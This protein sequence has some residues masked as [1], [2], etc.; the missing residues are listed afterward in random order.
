LIE[1]KKVDV[2]IK[3]FGQ[4]ARSY[5]DVHLV[6]V[7][8]GNERQ[9]LEELAK[10]LNIPRII[11][12][13][14][15]TTD[16][17]EYFAMCNVFVLPGLG[18]LAI[19]DAM[20]CRKP[21]ICGCA[22]GSEKDLIEDGVTGYIIPDAMFGEDI[23]AAKILSIIGDEKVNAEMGERAH[24]RYME[25]A[26]FEGMVNNFERAIAAIVDCQRGSP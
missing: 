22:D 21:V 20:V 13:G 25:R 3:A 14:S 18:G 23:L 9:S 1:R 24:L 16:V 8:G 19:N 11:F 4:I 10:S 12:V 26:T 2:L 15:K 17:Y 6:I 7:G 5:Q